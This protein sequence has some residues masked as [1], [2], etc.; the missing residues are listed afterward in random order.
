MLNLNRFFRNA[1][2]Y[3]DTDYSQT[4]GFVMYQITLFIPC[5]LFKN[6]LEPNYLA[7]FLFIINGFI[8]LIADIYAAFLLKKIG[9]I[10]QLD[11]FGQKSNPSLHSGSPP[12]ITSP[13][14]KRSLR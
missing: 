11:E 2:P 10:L 4:P 3:I 7:H 9:N 5:L 6:I 13:T 8:Q 12:D 1:L 14:I